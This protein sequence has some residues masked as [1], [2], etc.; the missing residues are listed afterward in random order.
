[1]SENAKQR[2]RKLLMDVDAEGRP[3]TQTRQVMKEAGPD[4]TL[5]DLVT[6]PIVTKP[7]RN[8][9]E[10]SVKEK[11]LWAAFNCGN[12]SERRIVKAPCQPG[13]IMYVPQEWKCLSSQL[14]ADGLGYEVQFRDGQTVR[15]R[16]PDNKTAE[17]WA[18]YAKTPDRWQSPSTMPYEAARTFVR[19]KAVRAERFWDLT[20]EDAI[21]EGATQVIIAAIWDFERMWCKSLKPADRAKYSREDDPWLWVIEFEDVSADILSAGME[22]VAP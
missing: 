9:N 21:K 2:F 7:G 19:V 8:G 20:E 3:K 16:F 10:R 14:D 15:F 6:D 5:C 17:K 11:G 12:S 22:F 1:M 4:W 13:D 18:K